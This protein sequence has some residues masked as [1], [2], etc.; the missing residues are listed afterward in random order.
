MR[1][2]EIVNAIAAISKAGSVR[3]AAEALAITPTALN[4]KLLNLEQELGCQLF[5]R[6]PSGLR[7]NSA[8]EIFL[9]AGKQQQALAEASKVRIADL[10]GFRA[11]HVSIAV[12][13]STLSML[14]PEAIRR[15]RSAFP[16]VTFSVHQVDPETAEHMLAY[17]EAD[18]ALVY[19][20]KLNSALSIL[21]QWDQ[22]IFAVMDAKHPLASKHSLELHECAQ[23]PLAL[24]DKSL[25]LRRLLDFEADRVG[26]ILNNQVVS[27]HLDFLLESVLGDELITFRISQSISPDIVQ[28]GLVVIP[29]SKLTGPTSMLSLAQLK[30]RTL[31]VASSQFARSLIV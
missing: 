16:A 21:H 31:S 7:M 6:I 24:P 19:L 5:E 15:Y 28:R 11:G 25:G 26:L 29:L 3:K 2:L 12:S 13:Q 8:G 30:G 4:R 10:V 22:E 14:L 18:L 1:Y 27:N 9:T 17:Y 23:Y 20:A